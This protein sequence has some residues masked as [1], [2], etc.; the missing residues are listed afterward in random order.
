MGLNKKMTAITAK[1][2]ESLKKLELLKIEKCRKILTKAHNM[3]DDDFENL[4]DKQYEK[5]LN[6]GVR[7]LNQL[8]TI[9]ESSIDTD[10]QLKACE[11]FLDWY[12]KIMPEEEKEKMRESLRLGLLKTGWF[13]LSSQMVH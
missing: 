12:F 9:T 2:F 7:A 10:V 11:A 5:L 1:T 6:D 4:S 3:S 8:T 13:D